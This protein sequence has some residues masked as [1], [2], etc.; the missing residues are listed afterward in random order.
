MKIEKFFSPAFFYPPVSRK[1]IYAAG[2]AVAMLFIIGLYFS[3]FHSPP[4]YQQ[5]ETTRIMYVHVPAAWMSLG[6]YMFMAG[7]AIVFLAG[8]LPMA[9]VMAHA[10]APL[11][12]AFTAITLI[13]GMLWGKPMWGAWWVWDARLTS[14]LLLLFLYLGYIVLAEAHLHEQEGYTSCALLLLIGT[15][16]IPIIKFSVEWW[17][18]L[19]QPA[20]FIK[21]GGPS[22]HHTMQLPLYLMLLAYALFF[23]WLFYVRLV[24]KVS[25]MKRHGKNRRKS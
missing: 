23:A 10:A 15:A 17:N 20:S 18:T 14:M 22:V 19:H 21:A 25:L 7:L 12:A 6:V 4:D 1:W 5:G 16:N 13:T 3:L 2:G 11:G 9:M 8:K 24:T